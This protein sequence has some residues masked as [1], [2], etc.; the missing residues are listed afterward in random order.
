MFR[1]PTC[2]SPTPRLDPDASISSG[3]QNHGSNVGGI[4]KKPPSGARHAGAF[5]GTKRS[6]S[7]PRKTKQARAVGG[8]QQRS[9]SAKG[10]S[11]ASKAVV[12]RRGSRSPRLCSSTTSDA[13]RGLS[14]EA[15]LRSSSHHIEALGPA[16][17]HFDP[18]HTCD[19]LVADMETKLDP[20]PDLLAR[21]R[22]MEL[23]LERECGESFSADTTEP[24]NNGC[25]VSIYLF[26][27][28]M[29]YLHA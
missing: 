7:S 28:K 13:R 27:A 22:S 3:S 10:M 19:R 8:Q 21:L 24:I 26:L 11:A 15:R 23:K 25:K 12:P 20:S 9:T 18:N 1:S 2:L 14:S 29:P 16:P 4:T 6:R 17:L 5:K